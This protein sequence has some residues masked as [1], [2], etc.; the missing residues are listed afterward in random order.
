MKSGAGDFIVDLASVATSRFK[1]GTGHVALFSSALMGT[2]SGSAV[3]NVVSTGSITI[4]MMKKLVS[5]LCL[6]HQLKPLQVLVV[7]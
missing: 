2:I 1:G 4:P 3:A 6:Q 5:N 7:K